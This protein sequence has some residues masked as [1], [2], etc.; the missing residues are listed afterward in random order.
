MKRVVSI[1]AYM[2]QFGAAFPS[3]APDQLGF[4]HAANAIAAFET[5]TFTKTNSDFD[6]FLARQDNA[7]SADAKR[8]GLLFFGKARCSQCHNGPMLGANQFAN[9]AIPQTR[10]RSWFGGA[11]RRG[12]RRSH[13][14][15]AASLAQLHVPR[16][17][18]PERGAHRALHARRGLRLARGGRS[19]LQQRRLGS[20]GIRRSQLDPAVRARCT[21]TWER[22]TRCCRH[23]ISGCASRSSSRRKSRSSRG[24]PEIVDDPSARNLSGV[25]PASVPSGL[26][27]R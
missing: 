9:I 8:G 26:P 25:A 7:M 4:Q 13:D 18:A 17:A 21:A 15:L 3:V 6:R 20:Q 1:P 10:A 2:Q 16:R 22:S 24:I 27:I 19:P 11:P 5:A 14:H 23:W 12:T